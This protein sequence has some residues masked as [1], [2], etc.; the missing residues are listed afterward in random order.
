VDLPVLIAILTPVVAVQ[1][2]L[3]AIGLGDLTRPG[4]QVRLANKPIWAAVIVV[5]GFVGPT[6]YFLL[7]REP[8]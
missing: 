5:V 3:I 1:L 6:L 4:R 7:G 2:M 8:E